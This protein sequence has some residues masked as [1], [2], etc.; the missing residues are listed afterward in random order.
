MSEYP[1]H[2]ALADFR[3]ETGLN[4]RYREFT[5]DPIELVLEFNSLLTQSQQD[6]ELIKFLKDE[7]TILKYLKQTKEQE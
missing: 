2:K 1:A 3:T 4:G 6:R 7:N 5:L